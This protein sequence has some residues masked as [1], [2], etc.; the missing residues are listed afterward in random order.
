[1]TVG[2]NKRLTK[3]KKGGKKKIVDPFTKKEWYDLKP[4]SMFKNRTFG[5]TLVTKT[6]GNKIASDGLKKRIFE[7]SLA[8]LNQ[9][10]EQ[11]YR[12]IK[13][14]CEHVVGRNCLTDFH[15][16]SFT[17]DKLCSLIKKKH[18]L[19][20]ASADVKTTDGYTLRMFCIAFTKR[21]HQQVK[22]TCYAQSSQ[23]K[24]LR[25]TMVDIM[26]KEVSTVALRDAVKKF[27]PESI[28][29]EIEKACQRPFPVENVFIRKVKIIKKPPLD[30]AKLMELHG[31]GGSG[32]E[33]SSRVVE[34]E[35]ARNPL[36]A[37]VE[38]AAEAGEAVAEEWE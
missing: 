16:M 4:P 15:G 1:M 36:A 11:S 31:E 24:V 21:A 2:K 32:E 30:L 33:S 7:V 27:I 8:D 13:L 10:D 26:K 18:T 20:E 29:K 28:G 37:E 9:D 23:I 19:I 22:A 3:G 6:Q 38:A 14:C 34:S 25:K 12:N 35:G 17:R 5:K